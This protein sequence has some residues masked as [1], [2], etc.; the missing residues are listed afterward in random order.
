MT[1]RGLSRA[2]MKV[3]GNLFWILGN[4][5]RIRFW[6]DPW[7]PG[8]PALINFPGVSVPHWEREYTVSNYS[9]NG[10][11]R[12]DLLEA[13]LPQEIINILAAMMPPVMDQDAD[14]IVLLSSRFSISA[15]SSPPVL[16]SSMVAPIHGLFIRSS[17]PPL[18]SRSPS[19]LLRRFSDRRW[20]PHRSTAIAT[21]PLNLTAIAL[22]LLLH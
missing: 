5:V 7:L 11:W 10:A 1:W 6:L 17:L 15:S 22:D 18:C 8:K 2:C 4:G 12:W 14:S 21:D 13:Y 16:R 3:Y 19:P 9:T 20:Q